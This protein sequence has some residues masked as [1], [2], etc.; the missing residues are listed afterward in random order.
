MK[1]NDSKYEVY[2][3]HIHHRLNKIGQSWEEIKT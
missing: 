3:N 1:I 2:V